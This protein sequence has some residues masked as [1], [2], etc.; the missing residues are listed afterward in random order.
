MHFGSYAFACHW[1]TLEQ[2]MWCFLFGFGTLIWGQVG[3]PDQKSQIFNS[4]ILIVILFLKIVTTIPTHK[5]PK[6]MTVGSDVPD[7]IYPTIDGSQDNEIRKGQVL[8]LRGIARLQTQVN[9]LS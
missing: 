7:A 6:N 2:W 5:L 8:W 1:L 3:S 4:R 9:H